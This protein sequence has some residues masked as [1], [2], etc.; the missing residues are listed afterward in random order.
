MERLKHIKESLV[1]C[2]QGQVGDLYSADSKELGEAI[3][4]IKDLSEAIYYCA[5]VKS[6]ED[7]EKE[8]P[9]MYY[10]E[11]HYRDYGKMYYDGGSMGSNSSSTGSNRY[12]SEREYPIEI[13]DYREGR[14]PMTRRMY[15][16]SKEMHKDKTA[17]M[18]E[19]DKYMQE[20]THD[21]TDMIHDST[22]EEK[23]LISSKLTALA[24]K[25]A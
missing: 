10:T 12:Y 17:Q 23:Q 18:R 19:L 13:R 1:S 16:E 5:I 6:M 9:M 2:V 20:L 4:M 8:K 11:P 25:I 24:G 7:S 14:S 21:I 3:D 15:I 22:P